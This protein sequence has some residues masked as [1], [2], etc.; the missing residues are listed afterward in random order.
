[1]VKAIAEKDAEIVAL[2]QRLAGLEELVSKLATPQ[3]P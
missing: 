1:M 2:R 3:Q